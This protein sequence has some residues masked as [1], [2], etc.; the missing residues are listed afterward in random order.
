MHGTFPE[1]WLKEGGAPD[2]KIG[3]IEIGPAFL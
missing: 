1:T 3:K 2:G